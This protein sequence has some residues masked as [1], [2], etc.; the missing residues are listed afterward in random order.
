MSLVFASGFLI[1][2]TLKRLAYFRDIAKLYPG[3]LF[4]RVSLTCAGSFVTDL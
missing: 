2:Q 3:A 4:P 1:P